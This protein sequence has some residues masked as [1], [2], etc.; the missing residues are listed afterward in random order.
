[1]GCSTGGFG[2]SGGFGSS[3]IGFG[4]S[5][6]F[7]SGSGN[8]GNS[9]NEM[10]GGTPG[11]GSGSCGIGGICGSEMSG[12]GIPGTDGGS[13]GI[14]GNK[15]CPGGF[16]TEAFGTTEHQAGRSRRI[17]VAS[18]HLGRQVV[19]L[20]LQFLLPLRILHGLHCRGDGQQLVLGGVPVALLDELLDLLHLGLGGQRD[21]VVA[22]HL[23]L[24]EQR[25]P[26]PVQRIA[27]PRAVDDSAEPAEAQHCGGNR[28][29]DGHRH[30]V[31]RR[32]AC[33]R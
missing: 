24:A 8:C 30:P 15:I 3:G 10:S 9:G 17:R 20:L 19:Q 23:L 1:M 22:G 21:L 29:H 32:E 18:L 14:G 13:C 7:G 16:G 12:N 4:C 2:A 26:Q 28:T 31:R 5:T 11:P 27:R 33:A 6:G 25:D